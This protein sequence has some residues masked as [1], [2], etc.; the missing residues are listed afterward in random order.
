MS[1]RISTIEEDRRWDLFL[2]AAVRKRRPVIFNRARRAVE[3]H[4]IEAV[5]PTALQG[6]ANAAAPG[7][8]RHRPEQRLDS[9]KRYLAWRKYSA[10]EHDPWLHLADHVTKDLTALENRADRLLDDL[11]LQYAL[12]PLEG[13]ERAALLKAVHLRLSETYLYA[14]VSYYEHRRM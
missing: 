8:R 13:T 9:L 5:S 3:E 11:G 2:E 14:L 4:D 12:R 1:E 10:D 7:P 6:L